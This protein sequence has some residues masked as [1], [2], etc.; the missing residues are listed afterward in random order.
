[1]KI[2]SYDKRE[3][4]DPWRDRTPM[5]EDIVLVTVWAQGNALIGYKAKGRLV[6]MTSFYEPEAKSWGIANVLAWMPFPEAYDPVAAEEEARCEVCCE[7]LT[8][9]VTVTLY[10]MDKEAGYE[11]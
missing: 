4:I 6:V 7:P 5:T 1:M 3:W 11:D 8:D 9:P 10:P 2:A